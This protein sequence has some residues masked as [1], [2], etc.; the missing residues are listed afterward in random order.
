VGAGGTVIRDTEPGQTLVGCPAK[1]VRGHVHN[2]V[3]AE[4]SQGAAEHFCSKWPF[5]DEEQIESVVRV[6]RSGN[7]NY[8]T[9]EEGKLFEREYAAAV[10]VKHA[11]AVAN[12]T[13]ALELALVALGV[14]P[15]DEVIVPCRTF[16][17]TASAVVMRGGKPVMADVDAF[18]QNVTAETVAAAITARTRAIVVVHLGGWPCDMDA[19]VGLARQK[20]LAV[21]EDCAQAHGATYKGRPVGSLGDISVFSFCQDKIIST[22]GE[23]G[24]VATNDSAL[25][26]KARRHKDHGK[27]PEKIEEPTAPGRFRYVHDSFG[28]NFRMTEMQAVIGRVQLKLLPRWVQIRREHARLVADSFRDRSGVSFPM[29]SEDY[30][31]SYYRLY[32]F[33]EPRHLRPGWTRDQVVAALIDR[34]VSSGVGSCG[35]I[36]LE[37]AFSGMR[38]ERRLRS[39]RQLN[40]T[41]FVVGIH[42]Y[43]TKADIQVLIEK[44]AGVFDMAF[45]QHRSRAA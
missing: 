13:L 41:S 4:P 44:C 29:P 6:L 17:A 23:G 5:Y 14:G 1:P 24:M 9:G 36:Y 34:G 30:G 20:G 21:V 2:E 38:P 37:A 33:V 11:I 40:Q 3:S 8:W 12:G 16:I 26:E 43:Q 35:E 22:G 25:W 28:T 7:V 15:G 10:G 39:A 45:Y 27:N 42:Q 19:I 32:G 31:H 18:S